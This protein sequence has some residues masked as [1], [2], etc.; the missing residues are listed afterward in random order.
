MKS[1]IDI[2]EI[3]SNHLNGGETFWQ[4]GKETDLTVLEF[5]RW[6]Y[7]DLLDNKYIL[8]QQGKKKYFLL[9]VK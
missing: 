6:Y 9:I 7:S 4:S 2:S 5:W 1:L 3:G 8:A